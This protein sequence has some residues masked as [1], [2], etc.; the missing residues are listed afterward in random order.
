MIII[1]SIIFIIIDQVSKII[2]V[3][4]LTNNKSI[5]VIKSFFYLTYTNNKG[6]A[7]SILTGRRILLILVALIVIG[8][9]IYYVRKNKIE[10]KVNKIALSLVIGG[11]IGNLIDRILRGAV[12][13]FID[14]KI[15]GYNFPIFN[16]AD[17]FIVIG[18]FLLIIEM[19]RKEHRND[20]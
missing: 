17:T 1:L 19:F 2:V 14:I 9:L 18:V 6:A 12:V 20:N 3:N 10:G 16:L 7:F 8:V 15:F 4:N 5:E 11:S 13:D